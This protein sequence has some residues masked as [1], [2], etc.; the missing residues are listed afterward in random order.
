STLGNKWK[1]VDRTAGVGGIHPLA[2]A[3]AWALAWALDWA[4]SQVQVGVVVL[5]VVVEL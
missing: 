2:S 1:R 5:V 3:L 4:S